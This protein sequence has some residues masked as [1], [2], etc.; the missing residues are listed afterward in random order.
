MQ[1]FVN[2]LKSNAYTQATYN[3]TVYTTAHKNKKRQM[4]MTVQCNKHSADMT[5]SI[6]TGLVRAHLML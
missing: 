6:H 5:V 3:T 2:P 4:E 1:Q